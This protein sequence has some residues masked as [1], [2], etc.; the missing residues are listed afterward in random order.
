MRVC[1]T[2]VFETATAT[3]AAGTDWLHNPVCSLCLTHWMADSRLQTHTHACLH[4]LAS[5]TADAT[6]VNP[7]PVVDGATCTSILMHE[8]AFDSSMSVWWESRSFSL[9]LSAATMLCKHKRVP[10]DALISFIHHYFPPPPPPMSVPHLLSLSLLLSHISYLIS[11]SCCY[12]T[13]TV[14]WYKDQFSTQWTL[15]SFQQSPFLFSLYASVLSKKP[16]S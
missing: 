15:L 1:A 7:Q 12:T 14:P 8:R 3:G 2:S 9:P 5:P 13:L 11:T 16:H 6:G 4:V 10:L